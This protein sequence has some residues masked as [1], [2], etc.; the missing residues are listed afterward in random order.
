VQ[1]GHA[2]EARAK[3]RAALAADPQRERN[4]RD[5]NN[6]GFSTRQ[7]VLDCAQIHFGF[8]ASGNAVE[9]LH[10]EFAQFETGADFFH[11]AFLLR[12]QLMGGWRIARIEGIFRGID[13]LF[14]TLEQ[15]VAQHAVDQRPRHFRELQQLRQRERPALGL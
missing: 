3:P 4:F 7:R 15:A 11:R 8:A 13:G 1:N 14:P 12:I 5:Q 10:A 2:F 6:C 9:Q